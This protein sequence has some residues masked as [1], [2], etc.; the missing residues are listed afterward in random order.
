MTRPE[1]GDRLEVSG[2]Y[3]MEPAWL[4]GAR[5]VVGTVVGYH[6]SHDNALAC[7]LR[8]D[9]PLTAEGL[10]GGKRE[11]STGDHLIISPRYVGQG[12]DGEQRTVQVGLCDGPPKGGH[13][14]AAAHGRAWVESHA[15][16]SSHVG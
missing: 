10:V 7:V 6:A 16:W 13:V 15:T 11:H 12:W 2:G 5:S 8:L 3:D 9:R 14:D 4:S 1:V